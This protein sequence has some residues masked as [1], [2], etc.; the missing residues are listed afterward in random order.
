MLYSIISVRLFL[1]TSVQHTSGHVGHASLRINIRAPPNKTTSDAFQARKGVIKMLMVS[2]AIYFLSYSPNQIL[3]YYK[4][5]SSVEFERTWVFHVLTMTLAYVNSAANPVLYCVFSAKFRTKFTQMFRRLVCYSRGR[6]AR[7]VESRES[8]RR[9]VHTS[10]DFTVTR[11][12]T[13]T[14]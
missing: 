14:K 10:T 11:R 13:R 3:L 4:M 1:G 2:V 9:T 12:P 8:T 6:R 7:R 5:F